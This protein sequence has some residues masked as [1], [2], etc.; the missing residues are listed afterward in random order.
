MCGL[1]LAMGK[2]TLTQSEIGIFRN[3]LAFD[4]L[5][6]EHSTGLFG[7][8]RP[9]NKAPFFKVN[10]ECL[11]G[12][13][14]VRSPL[15]VN[16]VGHVSQL[17]GGVKSTEWAKA[18]FGHNR[19]AT[20]GA[21]NAVNAHPFTHG[22]ITLAHN[23]TLRNQSLLPDSEKFEVDSENICYSIDKIGVAETIKR[24]HGAFAL[25]WL[26]LIHI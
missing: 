7:L 12:V 18:M 20:M 4:Q 11:E 14:F 10:K 8:F 24:L 25:I 22:H 16:T 15:F 21:V 26:S 2:H 23:G 13:D 19:Y 6:G 9:Y 3:M 1:V 5:R 17:A